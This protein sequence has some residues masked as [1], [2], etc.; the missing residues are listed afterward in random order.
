MYL[1]SVIGSF[2]WV[3]REGGMQETVKVQNTLTNTL[4]FQILT[5]AS[6]KMTAF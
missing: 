2:V 3:V 6:M 1:S 4:R 5:P